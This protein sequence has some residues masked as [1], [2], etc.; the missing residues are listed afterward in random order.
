M[1]PAPLGMENGV[2][3]KAAAAPGHVGGAARGAAL[4]LGQLTRGKHMWRLRLVATTKVIY[5]KYVQ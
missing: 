3:A 4:A 1:P 2:A 5:Y